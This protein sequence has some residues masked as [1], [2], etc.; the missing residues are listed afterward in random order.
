MPDELSSCAVSDKNVGKISLFLAR[1]VER[2]ISKPH[3]EIDEDTRSSLIEIANNFYFLHSL[4]K[5]SY[6]EREHYGMHEEEL[7]E[8]L[9]Y[10]LNKLYDI[11]DYNKLI[12][13]QLL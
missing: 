7:W 2:I 12:W 10:E 6:S 3:P 5:M 13:V 8:H 9:D 1:E 11:G 4:S